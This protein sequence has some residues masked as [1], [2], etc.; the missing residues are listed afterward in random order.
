MRH[1]AKASSAA[2]A[3]GNGPGLVRRAPI[4]L[5]AILATVAALAFAAAPAGAATAKMGSVSKV[6]YDTADVNGSVSVSG[7]FAVYAFQYSTNEVDWTPGPSGFLVTGADQTVT[8]ELQGL[9]G[10]TKYFVRLSV[11]DFS[12]VEYSPKPYPDFTTLT[13]D[14]PII[15]ATDNASEVFSLLAKATGKVKRPANEDDAFD[16]SC[17]F[18]YVTD[19][20]YGATGFQGAMVRP[21]AE[22]PIDKASAGTDKIVNAQLGCTNP[23]VEAPEGK[24]PLVPETTYHLRLAAENAAPGVVTKEAAGTFTTTAAQTAEPT[25]LTVDSASEIS[26]RTVK[27]AGS[28]ERPAGADPA[29]N[30]NCRFEYVAD[31][32]FK[33]TG[34]DGAGQRA[35]TPDP[36]TAS[37]P[38]TVTAQLKL[39][40]GP[41]Y[42][43]RLAAQNGAGTVTKEAASTFATLPTAT[44]DPVSP[45]GIDYDSVHLSGTIQ[46][47]PLVESYWSFSYSLDDVNWI[48]SGVGGIFATGE[49][50]TKAIE[51]D[52]VNLQ[53]GTKYFVRTEIID[54]D[55]ALGSY[56]ELMASPEPDP[57]FTTLPVDPPTV[58]ALDSASSVSYTTASLSG[59]ISRPANPHP[60][61]DVNCHFQY[62]TD[63]QF[64]ASGFENPGEAPCEPQG[65]PS[66]SPIHASGPS[67]VTAKLTGLLNNTT[68]HVRLRAANGSP[69]SDSKE[70]TF[71]TLT[72][73]L[74]T[75]T[76]TI[77]DVTLSSAH[78]S[79]QVETNIPPGPLDAPTIEAFKTTWN[80]VCRPQCPTVSESVVIEGDESS[81]PVSLDPI[82]LEAN[83]YYE[84][85]LIATNA[86]GSAVAESAFTTPNIAPKVTL[87]PGGSSGTGSFSIGGI[88]T[89]YNTKITDCHFEYGPTTE[90]VYR[91]PCSPQPV[92]RDEI[93]SIAVSG[94]EGDFK[95]VFRGQTTGDI[96]LGAPAE[97]VEKE[98]EALSAIGP[99]GISKVTLE[100][101]FFAVYYTIY[102]GGPLSGTNLGPLK[103]IQ[104]T[105]QL[106]VG[107]GGLNTDPPGFAGTIAEGG[108]ND[109]VI[110]E[111][112]LTGLTPG[113][114]YHYK[115][116]AT[117]NVG[118]VTSEDASFVAPPDPADKPC[119]N[120]AVRIENHSTRLPECRAYEL[121][122]SAFTT[123]Y[124][125][126][127]GSMSINEGTVSYSSL[128]GNINNS[129]YGGLFSNVYVAVRH[130]NGWDTIANLNGP[131]GSFY[132][133]PNNVT[134]GALFGA[135]QYSTDLLRSIWF[136]SL[137]GQPGGS[138]Y[139]R[140]ED[141]TFT[142]ISDPPQL[143]S[144][145]EQYN[146]A[147]ED[148]T[149]TF[150]VG[151]SYGNDTWAPGVGVGLYEFQGT[152]N[153][154]LPHR[155][156]LR[157]DG[158][159]ISE[160]SVGPFYENAAFFAKYSAD[161]KIVWF[162][163]KE[164]EGHK[165][166]VWARVDASKTYFASKSECTRTAG[167]PGG[168]CNEESTPYFEGMSRDGSRA[169]M[170]TTQQL[171][172]SDTDDTPDLY[173]YTLPTASDP[174]PSPDL[175]QVSGAA[176]NAKVRN[177]TRI[178]DN[179]HRIYFIAKGAPLA[180]N[181]DAHD[182]PPIAGD[183]NLYLWEQTAA[184][185]T[186]E[187]KFV[188]RLED[189]PLFQNDVANF[190]P[191][192]SAD[193]R[194]LVFLAYH[195]M[196]DTDTDNSLDVYRYDAVTGEMTRVSVDTAGV[197]GN[198]DF[199]DASLGYRYAVSDNGQQVVFTTS[200]ALSPDDGN[201]ASDAYLWQE[202]RTSLLS[203]GS[204][205][206]GAGSA[207]ID[208]SG[209]NIYITSG[210]QLTADDIDEV[211]DVY[212]IRRGGGFSFKELHH[213]VDEGCQPAST[214]APDTGAD[215]GASGTDVAAGDDNY[216]P[217]SISIKAMSA[218]QRASLAAGGEAEIPLKVSGPGKISL[219]GSARIGKRT[220]KVI[221]AASRA[222]QAGVVHVRVSLSEGAL[223]QLRSKGV[224]SLQL[225][226]V[227]ADSETATAT[228]KLKTSEAR[229]KRSK[230]GKG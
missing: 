33:E 102:F 207:V 52:V 120:E 98:L 2:C 123:G 220:S 25:I 34:F 63:E 85:E 64:K 134:G 55:P 122:T 214:P 179:G 4:V 89:P 16:V 58:L 106:K 59:E 156:D 192:I 46:S 20:Q 119:P 43:L 26:Y 124:G 154:G 92:G 42:H 78:F 204:V 191:Q 44:I 86:A 171:L 114:T 117:N 198:A 173:A 88:V 14:P 113:A 164:C 95:L 133:P 47:M 73:P 170:Y 217:A 39:S 131:R 121:V 28:L 79:G 221:A 118:T 45:A 7:S 219:N 127:L 202:G 18:E 94:T 144:V 168:A 148:L 145:L 193:G 24:C 172:N 146:G 82:R 142:K 196:V 9:K 140:Q 101:G 12:T 30:V 19:A 224:L 185:P 184:H 37:G 100:G 84:V 143:P 107:G 93:Q 75:P 71:T 201:G 35:C 158:T 163:V 53:G 166:Q 174:N 147:S 138:P 5:I 6:S 99:G 8:G 125:T 137:P 111:A 213:C 200:E 38:V 77:S 227:L 104:G 22:N 229:R 155:I 178:S 230:R 162:V 83:T 65:N 56:V 62:V 10:E 206:G 36:I 228:L 74:P 209:T 128:A 27:V 153:V 176:P 186:G 205:G 48:G 49:G 216:R 135:T 197:G 70:N 189:T 97:V 110:V 181:H 211:P 105:K 222:V 210:Q 150:W 51:G 132:A 40:S 31:R 177:L 50:G 76:L 130:E 80:V 61:F 149:H 203:T 167:D 175:I 151:R 57:S 23:A 21:C 1:H 195:P 182:L 3:D 41:T 90:Y 72:V 226:A 11:N 69:I 29:L 169:V 160:C 208:G 212:D 159:P 161:G 116:F 103:G 87:A 190:S 60:A 223:S 81:G 180:S 199:T 115:V 194:Y 129:G 112:G 225:A 136:L 157:N 215:N 183:Y 17:R 68:Y 139:L 66:E 188:T 67:K 126:S 91:A 13:V 109:P 218:S 187:T 108:N 141:G 165:E 15:T 96:T 54:F 152:G 32:Q